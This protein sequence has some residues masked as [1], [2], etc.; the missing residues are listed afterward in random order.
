MLFLFN[1]FH[2]CFHWSLFSLIWIYVDMC[3]LMFI[4]LVTDFQ[5]VVLVFIYIPWLLFVFMICTDLHWFIPLYNYLL[6]FTVIYDRSCSMIHEDLHG[7][8]W[9]YNRFI[10]SRLPD[11]THYTPDGSR[12]A[13]SPRRNQWF[14]RLHDLSLSLSLCLSLFLYIYIYIYI[15]IHTCRARGRAT[16]LSSNINE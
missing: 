3:L 6:G 9:I 12:R 4:V 13:D 11:W 7:F 16:L 5:L 8:T 14:T 2:W 1:G 15:Y 10:Y